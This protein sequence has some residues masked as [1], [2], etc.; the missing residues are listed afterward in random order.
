M[1][2]L[3]LDRKCMSI[4]TKSKIKAGHVRSY[5]QYNNTY[6]YIHILIVGL[7]LQT[8]YNKPYYVNP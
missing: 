1:C 5:M 8:P 3:Q 4:S 7:E 2:V 6:N